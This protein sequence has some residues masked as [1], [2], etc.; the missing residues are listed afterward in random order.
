MS[1]GRVP[2][3]LPGDNPILCPADDLLER[4]GVAEAFAPGRFSP[5]T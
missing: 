3:P 5:S 1:D 2:K 4:A